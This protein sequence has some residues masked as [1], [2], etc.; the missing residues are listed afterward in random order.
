MLL[1]E[2]R[3]DLTHLKRGALT[4]ALIQTVSQKELQSITLERIRTLGK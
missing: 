3:A 4:L 2:P 1:C